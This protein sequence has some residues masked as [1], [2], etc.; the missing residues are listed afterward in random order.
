[1]ADEFKVAEFPEVC[2]AERTE[3][4]LRRREAGVSPSSNHV[5][6]RDLVGL[7]LSGGGNRSASFNLGLIQ[8]LYERG[9][10]RHIDY[11]S[12]VSGGG[13][14]GA[15]LSSTLLQPTTRIDGQ[16]R[17][18]AAPEAKA[19][20]DGAAGSTT[21]ASAAEHDPQETPYGFPLA[22]GAGGRQPERVRELVTHGAYLIHGLEGSNRW[23]IGVVLVG[24]VAAS[25]IVA[26]A[27][28]AAYLFRWLDYIP[29]T[30]WMYGLGFRGD[31]ERYMVPFWIFAL[32]WLI[33]WV[34]SF[35]RQGERAR[36]AGRM[37]RTLLVLSIAALLV[38]MAGVLVTGNVD[39]KYR[40]NLWG[41][42]IQPAEQEMA[43]W[44]EVLKV[45]LPAALIVFLLPFLTPKRLIRSGTKPRHVWE[46]WVF[47]IASR[48]LLYGVPLLVFGFLASENVSKFN[49]SRI[50]D[51]RLVD[52]KPPESLER[53]GLSLNAQYDLRSI[54]YCR[55]DR[56]WR[57]VRV[58]AAQT[59]PASEAEPGEPPP[60][61]EVRTRA[62]VSRQIWIAAQTP[63][64]YEGD[65]TRDLV[66][67]LLQ[68]YEELL[69]LDRDLEGTHRWLHAIE[70]LIN[71]EPNDFERLVMGQRQTRYDLDR[72]S[73]RVT[74]HLLKEPT[75]FLKIEPPSAPMGW[76]ADR[77]RVWSDECVRLRDRAQSLADYIAQARETTIG[78]LVGEE[79]GQ[80]PKALLVGAA[81]R[82]F[83]LASWQALRDAMIATLR[84][85]SPDQTSYQE[86]L[87]TLR[88]LVDPRR[89]DLPTL[90]NEVAE[91]NWSI[92]QR[93]YPDEFHDKSTVF[94]TIVQPADQAYRL[95]VFGA[96][97]LVFLVLGALLNMNACSLFSYYR[98]Q[99]QRMWIA[100]SPGLGQTIPLAKLETAARGG[101]YH[102][103]S[104]TL[105]TIGDEAGGPI[106]PRDVF[107]FSRLYCGCDRTGYMP[108]ARFAGGTYDLASAVALSGAAL[109]PSYF[110]N[111]LLST[112]ML[113]TNLRLGQWLPNP[114]YQGRG[115]AAIQA[116]YGRYRPTPL[117]LLA[118]MAV[119]WLRTPF[120]PITARDF[121]YCYVADGGF[122]ENLGFEQL[123]RRRC[124]VVIVSDVSSDLD[125][126]FS[127]FTEVLRRVRS[128]QGIEFHRLGP[129]IAGS[130][131]SATAPTTQPEGR[132]GIEDIGLGEL[133]PTQQANLTAHRRSRLR[134]RKCYSR[135]HVILAEIHYP[136]VA[137]PTPLGE[138][139][140]LLIYLKPTLNGDEPDDLLRYWT[141]H[142]NF[143]HDSTMDQDYQA[144][145]FESYRYL[146]YHS[147][148]ALARKLRGWGLTEAQKN[149]LPELL[150][151]AFRD[152]LPA[153]SSET[154]PRPPRTRIH[155]SPN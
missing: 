99:L 52:L 60:P 115:P 96:A 42:D 134:D 8:A 114:A 17:A 79:A 6:P 101:P 29:W 37:S 45:A 154:T 30:D 69:Q 103:L 23:L 20:P 15:C 121:A 149:R 74:R 104:G 147:G 126:T 108:T 59:P 48:A 95:R 4:A 109:S 24:S 125:F 13:Y 84:T 31:F 32:A 7:S 122:I 55:W 61:R 33:T 129:E 94:A 117:G 49:E 57:L 67:P 78:P 144:D 146:G 110:R 128:E 75:I 68:D 40:R 142:P 71:R 89:S 39:Q 127:L 26:G 145:Q 83:D 1:M 111:P 43:W 120:R 62:D 19:Q 86:A 90:E 70:F 25:G 100:P 77:R 113:L 119:R 36:G 66:R 56:F 12:T 2:Q 18:E 53:S 141:E 51:A 47:E 3:I 50:R 34:L 132:R 130:A 35:W 46:G 93:L 98:G 116:F 58:E 73:A 153:T 64:V 88:W 148:E 107:T 118:G 16:P 76:P 92:L 150:G 97:F 135:S 41:L 139:T 44:A 123:L 14:A 105:K 87:Q 138:E 140:G 151:D 10:L 155:S 28:L 54:E 63:L 152:W 9:L 22:Q 131:S 102:L 91:V 80:T 81:L 136:S 65:R 5:L 11:L 21:P 38:G 82:T 72:V 133:V 106:A 112:L 85:T 124:R 137:G 27:A 143:P